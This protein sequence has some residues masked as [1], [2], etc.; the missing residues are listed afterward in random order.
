MN[1]S[2]A[3]GLLGA[4][5]I[6]IVIIGLATQLSSN[7]WK[8]AKERFLNFET[9]QSFY[10][11]PLYLAALYV[12]LYHLE[13][14]IQA[15]F[16]AMLLVKLVPAVRDLVSNPVKREA[17]FWNKVETKQAELDA[18]RDASLS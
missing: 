3:Y 18:K 17:A 14:A 10:A 16:I 9:L 2:E 4:A 11:I 15:Y 1:V 7:F 8:E 13:Y 5:I 6:I 12:V